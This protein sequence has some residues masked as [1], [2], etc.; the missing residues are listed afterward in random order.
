LGHALRLDGEDS[1]RVTDSWAY[2][3][4]HDQYKSGG[5]VMCRRA[6]VLRRRAKA[7]ACCGG[8]IPPGGTWHTQRSM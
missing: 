1:M 5:S 3:R 7:G 6:T 4:V 2:G 8:S